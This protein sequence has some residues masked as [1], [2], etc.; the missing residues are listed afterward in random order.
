M[1]ELCDLSDKR[2]RILKVLKNSKESN[3]LFPPITLTSHKLHQTNFNNI[4]FNNVENVENVFE[5]VRVDNLA[6]VISRL[7]L[8]LS[9]LRPVVSEMSLLLSNYANL[10]EKL[11]NTRELTRKIESSD[12]FTRLSRIETALNDNYLRLKSVETLKLHLSPGSKVDISRPVTLDTASLE[13]ILHLITASE[14]LKL[15]KHFCNKLLS[16]HTDTTGNTLCEALRGVNHSLEKVTELCYEILCKEMERITLLSDRLNS[17]SGVIHEPLINLPHTQDT[18][19]ITSLFEVSL[20]YS[21]CVNYPNSLNYANCVDYG[22]SVNYGNSV[23]SVDS[24]TVTEKLGIRLLRILV[25]DPRKLREFLLCSLGFLSNLAQKRYSALLKYIISNPRNRDNNAVYD[26]FMNLQLVISLVK[27]SVIALYNNCDL[28]LYNTHQQCQA[29][30][31]ENYI[32]KVTETLV[33]LLEHKL[34]SLITHTHDIGDTL[35]GRDTL[36]CRDSVDVVVR[37]VN[38]IIE[39]YTAIQIS[40]FYYNKISNI[41]T[42][43]YLQISNS[44]SS[45]V[46][47]F[48]VTQNPTEYPRDTTVYPLESVNPVPTVNPLEGESPVPRESPVLKSIDRMCNEWNELIMLKLQKSITVPLSTEDYTGSE[49]EILRLI[50]NFLS[51]IVSIQLEYSVSNDLITILEMTINPVINWCQ[52]VS[53][54]R[55]TPGNSGDIFLLN[56]YSQLLGSIQSPLVEKSFKQLLE[57]LRENAIDSIVSHAIPQVITALGGKLSHPSEHSLDNVE[58]DEKFLYNVKAVIFADGVVELVPQLG[59]EFSK[60]ETTNLKLV[61]KRIYTHL[62]K[63]YQSHLNDDT[64]HK[65][66][67][68]ANTYS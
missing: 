21:N 38:E 64:A 34:H 2:E 24:G 58:L 4:N 40:H 35:D 42:P 39:L 68:L 16:H 62:A 7:K 37:G 23:D 33:P 54:S 59:D 11:N 63:I 18:L 32:H 51:E 13:E 29:P 55:T 8:A 5:D 65:L 30:T 66:V 57:E 53:N 41:L 17:D 1:M 52:R 27:S 10:T 44:L 60:L 3:H 6:R 67:T 50:A 26:V 28:D 46:N 22:N 31:A 20:N 48:E 14:Q 15:S 19:N 61:L 9:V 36:D 47:S 56:A 49:E 12:D 25:L 43:P 45:S